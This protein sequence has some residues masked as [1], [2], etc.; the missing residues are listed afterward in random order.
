MDFGFLIN[1]FAW[2]M[3]QGLIIICHGNIKIE[4]E[5]FESVDIAR[6]F[7]FRTSQLLK[8]FDSLLQKFARKI[9]AFSNVE[10][11]RSQI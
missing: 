2:K 9:T 4:Q 1:I 6:N 11:V 7:H 10:T 3:S 5:C 8:K